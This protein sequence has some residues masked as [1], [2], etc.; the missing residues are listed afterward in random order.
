MTG[1]RVFLNWLLG[2]R[3]EKVG[4]K[5]LYKELRQYSKNTLVK[6]LIIQAQA[7]NK[8]DVGVEAEYKK[9]IKK[10]SKKQIIKAIILLRLEG[11]RKFR[12]YQKKINRRIA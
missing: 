7:N 12:R 5:E 2:N 9:E 11:N 4:P 3:P 10:Y 8:N 6:E 1:I